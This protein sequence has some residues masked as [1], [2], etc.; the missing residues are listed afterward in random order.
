MTCLTA[1]MEVL[2]HTIGEPCSGPY[3]TM[4]AET[5]GLGKEKLTKN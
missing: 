4:K 2:L 1:I 5:R 3:Q